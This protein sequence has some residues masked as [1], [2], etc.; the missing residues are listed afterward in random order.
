MYKFDLRQWVLVTS[1]E[2]LTIYMFDACYLRIC[3]AP[4][5]LKDL[6]DPMSHL[7]NYT[8]QKKG[9]KTDEETVWSLS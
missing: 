5:D 7:A 1:F 2:P 6:D 3:G 9:T 4:F 8:V